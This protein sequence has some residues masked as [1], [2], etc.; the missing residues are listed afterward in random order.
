MQGACKK[1][2]KSMALKVKISASE[3]TSRDKKYYIN[4]RLGVSTVTVTNTLFVNP[5]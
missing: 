1:N 4:R 2:A 5:K 3:L